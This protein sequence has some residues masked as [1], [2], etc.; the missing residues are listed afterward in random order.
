MQR[1][2]R[3][4]WTKF[5]VFQVVVLLAATALAAPPPAERLRQLQEDLTTPTG[6]RGLVL[7]D[8]KDRLKAWL[9]KVQADLSGKPSAAQVAEK[10]N[11]LETIEATL[12]L[13]ERIRSLRLAVDDQRDT[14][15]VRYVKAA[16]CLARVA[17]LEQS[18]AAAWNAALGTPAG[19]V[20][21]LA[22]LRQDIDKQ[23]PEILL[24]NPLMNFEKLLV[25]KGESYF[26]TNWDGP[27][28][29]GDDLAVVSPVATDG[30]QTILHH[31]RVA[32]LDLN[33]DGR[34]ILF[35][36][37]SSLFEIGADGSGLRQ[38]SAKDPPVWHYDGC[39]LPNGQIA[40]VSNACEQA[41]P[42]T[43]G[44]NVGNMHLINADGTGEHRVCF[45]QDQNWNP[46]V[47]NDGRI[48]Y[49]RWEYTDLPHY[50]SRMLFRMNPDGSGQMEY[51]G[52]GS[53][54]PNAMYWPKP[55][56][57][58]ATE[59][60]CIVSGH[61]GVS[62]V[63]ELLLLDPARGRHEADGVVQ[64]IPGYRRKVEPVIMDQLVID[65]WPKF[66]TPYPLAEPGSNLGAGK[67][68][69]VAMKEHDG[70]KWDIC[71]VDIYD[72][73][74]PI[75]RGGYMNPVPLRSRPVPPVIAS[76]LNPTQQDATIYL[77]DIYQGNGLRGFPRGSI[78]ALRVGSHEFRFA[79]NGDTYASSNEG[80]WDVKKILGTVPVQPDGSAL[81]HVPANTPIFVQPLDADGKA[82]QVMRSWYT[83]MAGETASCIGCHEQQNNTPP[84][85]YTMAGRSKPSEI[86]PWN[87]PTRGFSFDREVQPVLDHRCVG[88][89]DGS[90]AKADDRLTKSQP[91]L[92]AKQLHAGYTGRYSPAY[93]ALQMYVRRPGY[94]SDMH[95]HVAGEFEADTSALVQMLKKG[96]YNVQLSRDD[97]ERLYAW[98]DF[99]VPYPANWRESHVPPSKELVDRRVKYKKLFANI[100][101]RDEEPLPPA[102][103][104][105]FEAPQPAAPRP[106]ASL[107][108]AGWPL[109]PVEAKK[110]Q[111]TAAGTTVPAKLVGQNVAA[112]AATMKEVELPGGVKMKLVLIPAGRFVMGN[113]RGAIDEYPEA[114][115][116]I[117]RAFYLGQTEVTNAQYAAFDAKHDSGYIE[118]RGKDRTSRGTA[119]DGDEQPVVRISWNEAMGFCRWLSQ[120]RGCHATLPTEAQWEW[121]CR[122]G[123]ASRFS[124]GDALHNDVMNIADG[125]AAGWNYGRGEPGYNDG[126]EFVA[127]VGRF[128]QNPWGLAD[129]HGNVAEWCLSNYRPYPYRADDGRDDP[130]AAG[131]KVVR[132][133]S[134]ND[135]AKDATSSARWRYQPYQSTCTVGFRVLVELDGDA[136]L[137][138]AAK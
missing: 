34:R 52:S 83:A 7:A 61:H 95:M 19:N 27:N 107:Q 105:P 69:L 138:T 93:M 118:G 114:V 89:H 103:I 113:F 60:V 99:N 47:M 16:D 45:D 108:L 25:V 97:W 62:R 26:Q 4:C 87:G 117:P 30:K 18:A 88:C 58:N 72:N 48:L 71:L 23:S 67:Y 57:G 101:D 20:P 65:V 42:C 35:S 68:F 22:A 59:V 94:E 1:H 6:V 133:G 109:T 98:I 85:K 15:G 3:L 24:A 135:L 70:A 102:A 127:P 92:R 91:D 31:G 137:K 128:P 77:A 82:Q 123:T 10:Q 110:L 32:D 73:I 11:Q 50:F 64:R 53:Y 9:T 40:C 116:A 79:G 14:F 55:I 90:A 96:H 78:K 39:Y 129:M 130:G 74:T 120:Q 56:P 51:Y 122:A 49:V 37:G 125:R 106:K 2:H 132:G 66:A 46:T 84:S 13:M 36:D 5:C 63:G 104:V 41:V 75:L 44:A 131:L 28:H 43:G 112:A 126:N 76:Q 38:V 86:A 33:W 29:L 100:D 54:W 17:A 12:T 80:G 124:F 136:T 115:V 21:T 121:A 111:Q 134:W 8:T 119:I 81:F